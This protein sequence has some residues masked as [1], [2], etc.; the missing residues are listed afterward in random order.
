MNRWIFDP[1]ELVASLLQEPKR[2]TVSGEKDTEQE[3]RANKNEYCWTPR[4]DIS[5]IS[6]AY[7]I[8]AVLPGLRKEDVSIRCQNNV[9]TIEG[10]RKMRDNIREEQYLRRE[11][12]FGKF[13]RS[14]TLPDDVDTSAISASYENGILQISIP[15]QKEKQPKQIEIKIK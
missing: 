7:L 1:F 9:L 13:F 15:K 8:E 12:F 3:N 10:E 4:V 5:E 6:E 2:R 11:S 14:F